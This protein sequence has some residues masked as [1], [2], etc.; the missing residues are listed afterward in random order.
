MKII[1]RTSQ[2][3]RSSILII[4]NDGETL[5]MQV[6]FIFNPNT[7][8]F[9]LDNTGL[10]NGYVLFEFDRFKIRSRQL[11]WTQH[12]DGYLA[13]SNGIELHIQCQET[14]ACSVR[15][16]TD[17]DIRWEAVSIRFDHQHL[18][19]PLHSE[20]WMELIH[21]EDFGSPCGVRRAGLGNAYLKA[22]QPSNMIFGLS[23]RTQSRAILFGVGHTSQGDRS[24]FS[25]THSS[26]HCEAQFGVCLQLVQKRVVLPSQTLAASQLCCF[27]GEDLNG[28][29]DAYGQWQGKNQTQPIRQKQMGWN[30]WDY[31]TGS[32]S[33]DDVLTNMDK[34]QAIMPPAPDRVV[35]IDEGW[36]TRWGEWQANARFPD[37][38][39]QLASQIRDA[40][41]RP[42]IWTAPLMMSVFSP[43]YRLHPDWFARDEQGEV[44]TYRLAYGTMAFL[45]PTHPQVQDWLHALFTGLRADGYTYF[46]VDFTQMLLPCNQFSDPGVASGGAIRHAYQVIRDAIGDAYLLSCGAPY[47]QVIGLADAIRTTG[48]ILNFWSHVLVNANALSVRWWMH[49]NLWQSDPDFLVV[50]CP[51]TSD[52]PHRVKLHVPKP[53]SVTEHWR[54]G[55]EMQFNEVQVYALLVLLSGGEIILGDDLTMLNDKALGLIRTVL[56]HQQDKAAV[57]LDLFESHDQLPRIWGIHHEDRPSI[58]GL[59]NWTDDPQTITFDPKRWGYNRFTE[60]ENLW[61]GSLINWDESP[62]QLQPRSCLA[63]SGNLE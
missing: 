24:R 45:D 15:N 42:G 56:T 63:L 2:L 54:S 35:V 44:V 14:F 33:R 49:R 34:L 7:G 4:S 8:I 32:I 26:A 19:E 50:R 5:T 48:D 16:T 3:I 29:L 18:T 36:E 52:D 53:L 30:S 27:A 9:S 57:P 39:K 43:V 55:R 22:D 47:E 21:G 17:Q 6:P 60:V 37:G 41:Y 31:F 62:V 12:G 51:Q 10:N 20:D 28:L 59:I 11:L 58:V 46:K 25:L 23:H 13:G 38:M 61:D 1:T 40:G